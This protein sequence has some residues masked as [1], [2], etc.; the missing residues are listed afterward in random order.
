MRRPH[1]LS[2]AVLLLFPAGALFA[3]QARGVVRDSAGGAPIPGVVVTV[4][5]TSGATAARVITDAAGRFT[6]QAALSSPRFRL[7]R[8]GY[9]PREIVMG[10][11]RGELVLMMEKIPPVLDRVRVTD[12][13][14][15]PGSSDRG[16]A[17]LLWEQARAGLLATV[18]ARDQKPAD[19]RTI[20]YEQTMS[21]ID[22]TI[23]RQM[24]EIKSGRTSRP[25]TASAEPAFF[26]RNGYMVEDRRGR[27]FNAPDADV[28]LDES[29]VATHCFRLRAA[30]SAHVGQ[31]G[32]AFSPVPG[33]D[34]LVDVAG[35]IWMDAGAAQ[36]RSLD[37]A[38]T[39]LEPAAV[40]ARAG[41]H[42]EFR[43]M[44]NGVAFIER[45]HLRLANVQLNSIQRGAQVPMRAPPRQVA[46]RDRMDV[47]VVELIEAG[48][49]VIEAKWPDGTV[50]TDTPASANG[51]VMQRRTDQAVA[52]AL[53]TLVGTRDTAV[54]DTA[55]RFSISAI[56][57]R[58]L[59]N[60]TDTVLQSFVKP[61]AASRHVMVSRSSSERVR[62]DLPPVSDV[63]DDICRGQRMGIGRVIITGLAA[64]ADATS[65]A[66]TRI[67]GRWKQKVLRG[68]NVFLDAMSAEVKLDEDGRFVVCGPARELELTL[69]L[70]RGSTQL[71]DTTF[72]VTPVGF[73][74]R[75]L[76]LVAPP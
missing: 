20:V 51:V 75:V 30:D 37:F 12:S 13:E 23:R 33:R 44:A 27:L 11:D 61:R 56:P 16:A 64:T 58:Y 66:G 55:G 42:I 40:A 3:Q 41:G 73:S 19:A 17:F 45:W 24:K 26:A 36:L 8:I 62:I 39:S 59:A 18:V 34:T 47:R 25:F 49:I 28:L 76:W 32:L 5:D 14:L 74:Q 50:W 69:R 48:G 6:V 71:A 72:V 21:P 57:G 67:E 46:R 63:V 38:Y 53:V 65:L 2:T 10:A 1:W 43:T 52:G 22:E 35:V 70:F 60:V 15:C 29:F 54:T 31:T 7:L 9:R 4:L 68:T